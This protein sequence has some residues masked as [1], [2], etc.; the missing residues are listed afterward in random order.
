[1]NLARDR[2]DHDDIEKYVAVNLKKIAD[3]FQTTKTTVLSCNNLGTKHLLWH[4]KEIITE[5]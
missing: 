1:M 5:C 4:N 2:P 3:K